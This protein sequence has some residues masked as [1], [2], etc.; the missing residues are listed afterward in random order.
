MQHPSSTVP[1]WVTTPPPG[2]LPIYIAQGLQSAAAATEQN[3]AVLAQQP[4]SQ[5]ADGSAGVVQLP[6]TPNAEAVVFFVDR[7]R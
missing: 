1:S 4:S 3:P 7:Q 6:S 5:S 2:M